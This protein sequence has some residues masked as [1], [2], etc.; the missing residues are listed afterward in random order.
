MMQ[1]LES[2]QQNKDSSLQRDAPQRSTAAQPEVI[3]E[4]ER[5]PNSNSRKTSARRSL[6]YS[7]FSV[8]KVQENAHNDS[9]LGGRLDLIASEKNDES[10][11]QGDHNSLEREIDTV[12]E[13]KK[14][15]RIVSPSFTP[16]SYVDKELLLNTSQNLTESLDD[17][18]GLSEDSTTRHVTPPLSVSGKRSPGERM[19]SSSAENQTRMIQYLV[20]ELR[21]L[22][23]STG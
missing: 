5:N 2:H 15:V 12:P 11:K 22:L 9:R 14:R 7:G 21:A 6:D 19:H 23:G 13:P 20:D 16:S 18:A 3:S 10:L 1:Q 4:R 8:Q 17:Q